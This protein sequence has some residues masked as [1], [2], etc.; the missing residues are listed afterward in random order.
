MAAARAMYILS[1][2]TRDAA[3]ERQRGNRPV[4]RR[5]R[6]RDERVGRAVPVARRFGIGEVD[7]L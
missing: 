4:G 6:E 5:G 7:R 3:N 1:C 2:Q